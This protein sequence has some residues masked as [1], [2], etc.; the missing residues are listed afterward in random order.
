MP[1]TVLVVEDEAPVLRLITALLKNS[2]REVLGTS[3][4]DQAI[5]MARQHPVDLVIT[6]VMLR[7]RKG[8]E[9]VRELLSIRPGM[10]VLFVSGFPE[11]QSETA[12]MAEIRSAPAA[13]VAFLAKPFKPADLLKAVDSL[14]PSRRDG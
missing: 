3:I 2:G 7:A 12:E 4:C 14:V 11:E 9:L 1:Q 8:P 5:E 10:A 6:D 13:K